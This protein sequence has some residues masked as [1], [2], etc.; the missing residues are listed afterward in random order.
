VKY[1]YDVV[2]SSANSIVISDAS[3]LMSGSENIKI[4]VTP[5]DASNLK[6]TDTVEVTVDLGNSDVESCNA[7][8][9]TPVPFSSFTEISNNT[10]PSSQSQSCTGTWSPPGPCTADD[11]ATI[12]TGEVGK[13]GTGT[14][15]RT[16][17]DGCPGET[18][19]SG[20]VT[21][22]RERCENAC[23]EETPSDCILARLPNGEINWNP[24]PGTPDYNAACAEVCLTSGGDTGEVYASADVMHD[25]VGSGNCAYSQTTTCTCPKDCTGHWER[26]PDEVDRSCFPNEQS[27]GIYPFATY[28]VERFVVD[29][30]ETGATGTCPDRGKW[31]RTRTSTW[32]K[33]GWY[34][35]NKSWGTCDENDTCTYPGAAVY[36]GGAAIH[37]ISENCPA[38]E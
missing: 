8:G 21:E 20:C 22:K 11:G 1:K 18:N 14:S 17:P 10:T 12:L 37:D 7:V 26:E 32:K 19:D 4:Y 25:A 16:C 9:G 35:N 5:L 23:P 36:G 27:W 13:C 30:D 2:G 3:S 15:L 33:K 6:L 34:G 38:V 29:D 28:K 24:Y 31:R